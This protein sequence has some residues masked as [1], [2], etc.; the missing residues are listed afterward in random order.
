MTDIF[1]KKKRSQ[2][3]SQIRYKWTNPEKKA[4]NFLKG[5]KISHKMHPKGAP[6]ADILLTDTKKAILLQGCFWHGCKRHFRAP[7]SN[8]AFW[9]RKL[10]ANLR[11]DRRTKTQLKRLGF[12]VV[13]IWE[14]DLK[15]NFEKAM[16]KLV[17][18]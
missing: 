7:K 4:H 3:M 11:R 14:H 10:K 18:K 17:E 8:R 1:S 9:K 13:V 16:K 5:H 6:G 15:G 12:K 2:I